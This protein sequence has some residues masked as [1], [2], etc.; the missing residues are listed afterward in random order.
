MKLKRMKRIMAAVAAATMLMSATLMVCAA[1]SD[2][3]SGNNGSAESGNTVE[4][5][6]SVVSN[7]NTEPV[8]TPVQI[9]V[10][11]ATKGTNDNIDVAGTEVKTSVSGV[12]DVT[13]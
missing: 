3:A 12:Y 9:R 10:E 13:T 4:S 6:T 1:G 5:S 8:K 11:N 2:T 7:T